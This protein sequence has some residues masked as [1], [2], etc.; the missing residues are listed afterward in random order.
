MALTVDKLMN[1]D[2]FCGENV[3]Q[4]LLYLPFGILLLA[5]RTLLALILWVASIILPDKSG[6]RQML[7]TLACWTFGVYVKLKGTRDPR[8][9]VMVAN[10]VSCLDSLAASHVLST[11][12]LRKW[13]VPPFFAATLGIRN[14][15][16]FV[17]KQHFAESP[18]KPVLLQPEGGPT[19][20]KGLLRFTDWPFQMGNRVQPVAIS[21][22]RLFTNVTVHRPS[23]SRD[24]F[25]W[26]DALWFLWTPVT[27]FTVRVLPSIERHDDDDVAF[28]AN[29]R[30]NIAEALEIEQ[31]EFK[32]EQ[33]NVGRRTARRRD[34]P[35]VTRLAAQV[36]EV[37]PRVPL[38]DILRDLGTSVSTTPDIYLYMYTARRHA[39]RRAGQ[40]GAAARAAQRHP[41]GPR[42]RRC[43]RA[44]RSA[45][46]SGTSVSTTPDIY[47][48]M[49]TA[50]RHAPRRAGQG[51]AAARAAQRHPQGPRSRRCCRACRSATS[52]GT[53]VS[54]T[55]DIYLYM[56][57]ARRHAPRRAGQGG[58]AARAA[59]RHPQGPRSR[60]C[61]RACRSATSSG[62][63]V[64]TT[65][66]I[67]LYMYTARRHAPRRAGQGGAAARAAQRH[68]QGPR[69]RRC[70][71]ACRSATSS[72][73]SVSTTPDIYLY[74]YTARRHAPRRAGQGGA[75]ARAAQRHPQGPR[76]RR[77]CR[78]C[79][80]ATSSGTS[81]STTPD[82]Y[83]YMYTARR[84]APRRAG[85]GG[86]AARAAQRHPQGPRS[87]RCCRACRSATS[88]GTSVSTT[89][90][91]YLYMYTA[92]RHAPR[93]AGQG[94]AAAR[95]A[96][97]HP[98]GPRSRR[99]CRACRSATS[100]GTSVSTTP[101]I[102][103]YMYTA[104]RHAPRRA[105]QGGAAAR[106]A[107]RHPQGPR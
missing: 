65:P 80:S 14:A 84:H 24:K 64:S 36:K 60:R 37:L 32:W 9:S 10:Y 33:L 20:G 2:R 44:C 55:P 41:Q 58:A 93:R 96:Q 22:E 49:Y 82:I 83:L 97:R 87:R 45:T 101:D 66:D 63:S 48:Y 1:D 35:D 102:Y 99:C 6:I 104:R 105:G 15:S 52:S 59:Q 13:K 67:Y 31:T 18:S 81:V 34:A 17:R 38:S 26:S 19:N 42:S 56:Y 74:M 75:A 98:Q 78:A 21:V 95:A 85:Q 76:S 61:C 107:Q 103:L 30:E 51:G 77:C 92:R 11:I 71:R 27:V 73:T 54:T 46:S 53:S 70:C 16:Q 39:P 47:L 94:G 72:G 69:S 68:P 91:I 89:P 23:D 57:T 50:R 106:A 8:C 28:A 88:S 4:F 7:S 25:P 62:T 86:A 100:S 5:F 40:G 90:D 12:S 3:L 79:R 29:I 43:C